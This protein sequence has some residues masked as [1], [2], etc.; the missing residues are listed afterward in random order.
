MDPNLS[1]YGQLK[2]FGKTQEQF[3]RDL[4]VCVGTVNRWLNGK[5]KPSPLSHFRIKEVMDGYRQKKEDEERA[6]AA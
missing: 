2:Y 5:F 6:G 1:L 4:G 3:A